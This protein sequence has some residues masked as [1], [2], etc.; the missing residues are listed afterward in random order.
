MQGT[1]GWNL[2][3]LRAGEDCIG[4]TGGGREMGFAGETGEL[5]ES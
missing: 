1:V 3:R 5:D 4:I 2:I